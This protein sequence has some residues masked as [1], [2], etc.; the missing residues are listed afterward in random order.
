MA[1]YNSIENIP[2]KLFFEVLN[3]RD[4]TLL[5]AEQE[6]ED[7]EAIFTEI[8]DDFFVKIN[9]PQAK[10]YLEM[11]WKVNFLSYKIE[12]IRQ[13][14]HFLWYEN[15]IEEHRLKILD[16]LEK[17]C[18]IYVDKSAKFADEVLRVLQVECGIIEND[19]TMATLELKNTF[20][21]QE[22]GKFDFYK[23]IVSLSNIHNRNIEDNIVLAMYVAIENS[24][25]DIIK[26][27]KK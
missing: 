2:A 15:V 18:G 22:E 23:T 24:A 14:M 25:K 10:M 4:Y 3:T 27:Q 20:G 11:T 17:G 8:Y 7:L 21:K 5:V 19:L 9:N 26:S 6:N 13:V 16:A 12:T 1:K